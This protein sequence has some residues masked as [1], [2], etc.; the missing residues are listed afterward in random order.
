[1][2][3]AEQK[4]HYIEHGF[5]VVPNFLSADELEAA[6]DGMLSYFPTADELGEYPNRY[7]SIHEEPEHQ[8]IEFPYAEDVLNDT[9]TDP[10]LVAFARDVLGTPE[11]RLTQNAIWAKYAG[12]G[13]YEQ[14]LHLD[15]QG[16]TLVVPRDDGD[17]RQINMIL[18]LTDVSPEMGTTCLVSQT[19]TR[20][21]PLW[22]THRPR[23]SNAALYALEQPV[24]APAGSLMVFSMRTWHRASAMTAEIGHRFSQ[25]FI[26]RAAKHDFQG[27]HLYSRQ[28]ESE[29]LQNFITRASR[30]QREVLGFPKMDDPYWTAETT[31]AVKLRYPGI[32]L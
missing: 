16:N 31:E 9:A 15:Y 11:V 8:Q 26:W 6:L 29:E 28:G 19:K 30:E 4:A 24:I 2:I 32:E 21:L 10:R 1:M 12:L 22:P 13:D 17:Y 3:T 7:G 14:S 25:H 5:V 27:F 20:D 18:Y 23:K